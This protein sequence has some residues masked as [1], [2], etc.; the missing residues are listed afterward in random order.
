MPGP[1]TGGYDMGLPPGAVSARML[2][3]A[4]SIPS[5]DEFYQC[6]RI[7]L[8]EDLY[9]VRISPESPQGVHHQ[10]LAIDPSPSPDGT[11]QGGRECPPTGADWQPLYASGVGTGPLTMPSQVAFKAM[12]GQQLVLG[13]HLFNATGAAIT[14]EVGVQVASVKDATGYQFAGFPYVG[15]I[16][17]TVGAN[18]TVTGSCKIKTPTTLFA[19][20]PHMHQTGDHLKIVAGGKTVWDRPYSFNEQRFG[21]AP[22]WDSPLNEIKLEADDYID[23]ECHYATDGVGKKF[24]D[25]STEEMC[26]GFAFVY[27]AIP[28][29][30]N[31]PYCT[32][33]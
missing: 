11:I 4:F 21:A 25:S 1:G 29:N 2:V 22:D 24:G 14:G 9:V 7:T 19:V 20:F 12:K 17:F 28:T 15:P 8:T 6:Q 16:G 18:Q 27:P 31:S 13:L 30:N 10:V 23:V 26:F 32:P 3:S 33:F 5:G